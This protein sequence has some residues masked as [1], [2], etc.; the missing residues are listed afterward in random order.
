MLLHDI[1]MFK[2]VLQPAWFMAVSRIGMIVRGQ[3][4]RVSILA[5]LATALPSGAALSAFAIHRVAFA[6]KPI[7]AKHRVLVARYIP[8]IGGVSRR[9]VSGSRGATPRAID[10]IVF[11][12]V[13]P[14]VLAALR[15]LG[16]L[17]FSF[18]STS[19]PMGAKSES[20]TGIRSVNLFTVLARP[21]YHTLNCTRY[22]S[23]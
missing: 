12:W 2:N 9:Q 10:L 5:Y 6:R 23:L 19:A 15:T 18:E 16:N 21:F 11:R 13:A 4:Q 20:Y 14:K 8:M 1:A 22:W 17:A 7:L 3:Y